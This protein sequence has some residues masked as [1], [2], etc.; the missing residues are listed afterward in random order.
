[1]I[2]ALV[3]HPELWVAGVATRTRNTDELDP[4]SA[5]RPRLWERAAPD[6]AMVA[7]LTDYESGHGG[8]FTQVVGR[9][10]AN[11]AQAREG[12]VVVRVPAAR[13][14]RVPTRGSSPAA[15]V[16]GWEAIWDAERSGDLIRAYRTDFEVWPASGPPTI[17]LS[18]DRA[19]GTSSW[20]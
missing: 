8:E 1:M 3:D 5:R 19:A 15:I 18:V 12:Q 20:S 11:P 6:G 4:G 13:Y 7:V 10:V 2:H 16:S 14:S 9:V 17:Y